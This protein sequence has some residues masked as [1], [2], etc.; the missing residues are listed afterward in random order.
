MVLA[1]SGSVFEISQN[2]KD[3]GIEEILRT[4]LYSL[5]RA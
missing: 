4:C 3:F 1:N 2:K 5:P